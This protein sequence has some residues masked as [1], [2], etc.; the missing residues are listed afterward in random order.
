MAIKPQEIIVFILIPAIFFLFVSDWKE[1][2]KNN[3]SV[4]N[5]RMNIEWDFNWAQIN[6]MFFGLNNE[7]VENRN[8]D[9]VWQS[10]DIKREEI[11]K[12]TQQI[13]NNESDWKTTTP[14]EVEWPSDNNPD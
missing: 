2:K 3:Q 13:T 12:N 4:F 6:F 8:Q 1:E 10:F 11:L 5:L 7:S 14:D 9:F